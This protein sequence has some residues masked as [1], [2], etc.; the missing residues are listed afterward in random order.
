MSVY[1]VE[2][3]GKEQAWT[4]VV[5]PKFLNPTPQ[6][7]IHE[8]ALIG[9]CTPKNKGERAAKVRCL[10]LLGRIHGLFIER[11]EVTGKDG[12]P[13]EVNHMTETEQARRVAWILERGLKIVKGGKGSMSDPMPAL[14]NGNAK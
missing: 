1:L 4:R 5:D 13:I 7:V 3:I 2:T 9:F 11:H 12:G 14:V 6:E 8:L 10:A